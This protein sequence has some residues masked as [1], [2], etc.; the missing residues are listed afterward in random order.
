[1]SVKGFEP[2]GWR[3][4]MMSNFLMPVVVHLV[5]HDKQA[6]RILLIRRYNTG[7]EDGF[8]KVVD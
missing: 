3:D 6:D 2:L 8:K 5:L 1:M 4:I 7:Y